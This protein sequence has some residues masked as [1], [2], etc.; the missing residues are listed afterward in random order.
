MIPAYNRTQYLEEMLRSVLSQDP[1]AEEMQIE[2][3]DDASLLQDPEPLVRRIAGDRVSFARNP[4][5]IGLMP[6]F[7]RCVERSRGQWVHILHTDDFV[8]PGFYERLKSRLQNRSD[9]GA[10]FCRYA[11]IDENGRWVFIS[12]L[13]RPTP[14][15]LPDFIGK[16][17]VSQR[18][19]FPAIVVRRSVYEQL[20]GFRLDLPF[21]ADWE[22]WIRIAAHYNIW[23][24]PTTLAAWRH[25]STSATAALKS[26]GEAFSDLLRCIEISRSWLPSGRAGT[27]SR[28]AKEWVY[29]LS[30]SETSQD[31]AALHLVE[32]LIKNSATSPFDR[33]NVADALLRAAHIH[34]RQGRPLDS[35]VFVA[36]AILTRPIVAGRPL[37]RAVV[38]FF[39]KS[40]VETEQP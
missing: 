19:Q 12:E 13:E 24:E 40:Q 25:H 35:L 20:G 37:K 6:N 32:E 17:G 23:Y 34:Y 38:S 9:V 4:H 31:Q 14:G 26:S 15:I 1:G 29:L 3:V 18:I 36:R 10:A 33:I 27:I 8:L 2:I 22:L 30:L 21:T 16:I 5:N 39:Q 7:N 28:S 11:T